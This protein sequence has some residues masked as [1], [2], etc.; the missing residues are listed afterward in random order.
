M[1]NTIFAALVASFTLANLAAPANAAPQGLVA[2]HQM[3]TTIEATEIGNRSYESRRYQEVLS[4]RMIAG[5]L[6]RQGFRDVRNLR[7][8]GR[9]YVALAMGHRGPVALVISARSGQ[10]V[11]V[12]RLRP[13]HDTRPRHY[14]HTGYSFGGNHGGWSWSYTVR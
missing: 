7:F 11:N 10:I 4:P 12:D 5:G 13:R 8:D 1:K 9:N 6:H 3:G 2:K 14:G